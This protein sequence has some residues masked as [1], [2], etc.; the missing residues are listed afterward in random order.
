MLSNT[1]EQNNIGSIVVVGL[2][3]VVGEIGGRVVV[4]PPSVVTMIPLPDP[5]VRE[6]FDREFDELLAER[7]DSSRRSSAAGR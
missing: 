4:S 3:S 6:L 1:I 2:T 7:R 5:S